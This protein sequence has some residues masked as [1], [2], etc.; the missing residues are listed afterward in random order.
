M[1]HTS[2][3]FIFLLKIIFLLAAHPSSSTHTH[4]FSSS[5]LGASPFLASRHHARKWFGCECD[6]VVRPRRPIDC[7]LASSSIWEISHLTGPVFFRVNIGWW[8]SSRRRL[9]AARPRLSDGSWYS[10]KL[11]KSRLRRF[12]S[13][14]GGKALSYGSTNFV[15][16]SRRMRDRLNG[17]CRLQTRGRFRPED[18]FRSS[19]VCR[20]QLRWTVRDL[21]FSTILWCRMIAGV[22]NERTTLLCFFVLLLFK[23]LVRGTYGNSYRHF[24]FRLYI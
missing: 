14:R 17:W 10:F 5:V 4:T 1:H 6:T 8:V 11:P 15:T 16:S 19:L 2:T 9:A 3:E 24:G 20:R 7:F 12:S 13:L 21:S 18:G 23:P 22:E